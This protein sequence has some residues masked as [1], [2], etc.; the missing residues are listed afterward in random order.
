MAGKLNL[1]QAR[2]TAMP[3]DQGSQLVALHDFSGELGIK[4]EIFWRQWLNH[5]HIAR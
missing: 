4:L 5:Q 2:P 3:A 1:T